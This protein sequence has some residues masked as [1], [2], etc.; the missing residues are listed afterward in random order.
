[1]LKM[2]VAMAYF[3]VLS[4]YSEDIEKNHKIEPVRTVKA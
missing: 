2:V 4:C 3:E 1:M